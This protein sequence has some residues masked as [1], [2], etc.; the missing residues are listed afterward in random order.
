M[1]EIVLKKPSGEIFTTS[2]MIAEKF[3]KTHKDVL[4]KIES[5]P[6][7]DFTRRNF[8]PS[9]YRDSSGKINKMYE[10]T[11]QGFSILAMRFTG[12]KAYQWQQ[13]FIEAFDRMERHIKNFMER[14]WLENRHETKL[15]YRAMCR[16][17]QEVRK[18]GGKTTAPHH[19]A[20]EAKLVNWAMVDAFTK[21]DRDSLS[22]DDLK[23]LTEL[24]TYNAVLIGAGFDREKRKIMLKGRFF[25]LSHKRLEVAA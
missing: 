22:V 8:T 17:L 20:N 6:K 25:E 15:E 1:M 7:D 4:R 16:T 23:I 19:F 9:E 10:M 21:L 11:R 13:K 18:L 2:L 12:A 14:G 24:E 5:L 3:D